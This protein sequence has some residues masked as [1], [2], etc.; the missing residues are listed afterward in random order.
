MDSKVT[1]VVASWY[2]EQMQSAG[3]AGVKVDFNLLQRQEALQYSSL[4]FVRLALEVAKQVQQDAAPH[5]A[6]EK[7]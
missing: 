5:G 6:S 7:L 4:Y 1:E 3:R 2:V